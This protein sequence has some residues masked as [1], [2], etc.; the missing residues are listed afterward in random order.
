MSKLLF[1]LCVGICVLGGV[2][3]KSGRTVG[4]QD[5]S[6][7]VQAR[8]SQSN[9]IKPSKAE[10]TVVGSK[11]ELKHQRNNFEKYSNAQEQ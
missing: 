4:A 7:A 3:C 6:S 5:G 11:D 8:S 2:A 10:T 1:Y 9:L